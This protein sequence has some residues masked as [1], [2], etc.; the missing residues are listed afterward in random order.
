MPQNSTIS[1]FKHVTL[2]PGLVTMVTLK[3]AF[4][5]RFITRQLLND[6]PYLNRWLTIKLKAGKWFLA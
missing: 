1:Q 6:Q 3:I 5:N 2:L 4:Y